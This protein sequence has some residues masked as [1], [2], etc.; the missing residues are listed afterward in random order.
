MN[1]T[2]LKNSKSL[3]CLLALGIGIL[4]ANFA[5]SAQPTYLVETTL[6][7]EIIP[8]PEDENWSKGFAAFSNYDYEAAIKYL[9]A[10]NEVLAKYY[11]A[12]IYFGDVEVNNLERKPSPPIDRNKA[13]AILGQYLGYSEIKGLLNDYLSLN[14]DKRGIILRERLSEFYFEKGNYEEAI[15]VRESIS[16]KPSK[17]DNLFIIKCRYFRGVE[18]RFITPVR[19]AKGILQQVATQQTNILSS[20]QKET[21]LP[22]KRIPIEEIGE[23]PVVNVNEKLYPEPTLMS[24]I[25]PAQEILPLKQMVVAVKEA[26][27]W[28]RPAIANTYY[29]A[30]TKVEQGTIV[31]I[32]NATSVEWY[33]NVCLPDGQV[34]WICSVL[35]KEMR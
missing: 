21:E 34:G 26:I 25:T 12:K 14:T 22:S 27:I 20:Q 3:Y 16:A 24:T 5:Q 18:Q 4:L 23:I 31:T 7:G 10:S 6:V 33:Y 15:K 29:K 2:F 9:T 1:L 8:N 19:N 11:L 17:E 32:L 35:L 30:L 28:D 13:L